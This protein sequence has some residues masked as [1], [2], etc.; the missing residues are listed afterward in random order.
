MPGERGGGRVCNPSVGQS[1][2]PDASDRTFLWGSVDQ[3]PSS[4][5]SRLA[6]AHSRIT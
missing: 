4:K 5:R 1:E 2:I 6:S 3:G